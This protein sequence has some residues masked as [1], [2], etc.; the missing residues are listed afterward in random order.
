[1]SKIKVDTIQSTQHTTSTIGFTSTGATINGDCSATTFTGSGA[2]LTS[3]PSAN[4]TGAIPA[5]LLTNA[6][7][8]GALEFVKNIQPSSSVSSI[9]ETGLEYDRV[10]RLVFNN[11]RFDGSDEL[12][13][14][15]HMDNSTSPYN[16]S[17]GY[18]EMNQISMSYGGGT[19]AYSTWTYWRFHSNGYNSLYWSGSLDIATT[20]IPWMTGKLVGSTSWA[21]S[22]VWG[23][24]AS[25][26]NT[27]ND[28]NQT[29]SSAKVNGFTLK[30]V[31]GSNIM[32][33]SFIS[34]YKLK[35]S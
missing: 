13:V 2:N 4:L 1:M 30:S 10:Y 16:N 21:T 5:N 24:K 9:V 14:E 34:L 27:N 19:T 15:V 8:G 17:T 6:G 7:G 11:L 32:N 25:M 23:R 33:L 18:G 3:L 28:P 29:D 20:K 31:N 35:V 26:T 12:K 22:T